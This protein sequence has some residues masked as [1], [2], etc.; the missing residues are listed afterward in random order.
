MGVGKVIMDIKQQDV[1]GYY[2]VCVDD[3]VW[4]A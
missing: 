4:K 1:R 2:M 3:R